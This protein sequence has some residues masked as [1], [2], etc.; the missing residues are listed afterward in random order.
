VKIAVVGSA[1]DVR[2]FSL[3]GLPGRVADTAREAVSALGE[4]ARDGSGTALLLVSARAA[5]LYP[6]ELAAIRRRE[7]GPAVLVLPEGPL[8]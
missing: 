1:N 3:V 5:R 6:D 4:E 7:G 8:P 2:G